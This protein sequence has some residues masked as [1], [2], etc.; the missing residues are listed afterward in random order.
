MPAN[1]GSKTVTFHTDGGC[2]SN[3]GPGGWPAVLRF[4]EHAR[5]L[6]GG[7]PATTNNRMELQAASMKV[8]KRW[9]QAQARFFDDARSSGRV[10]LDAALMEILQSPHQGG[11]S[12]GQVL[13]QANR[14]PTFWT[15]CVDFYA[16]RPR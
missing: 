1:S 16:S 14:R 6:A 3:P 4:G 9:D 5:E 15:L 8:Q 13:E 11:K 12:T 2:D 10:A 7:E